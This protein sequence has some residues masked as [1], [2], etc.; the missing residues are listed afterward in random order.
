MA[1]EQTMKGEYDGSRNNEMGL[2]MQR[3]HQGTNIH[4][5]ALKWHCFDLNSNPSKNGNLQKFGQQKKT[6]TDFR[7]RNLT[8]T[9]RQIDQ[10]NAEKMK[11]RDILNPQYFSWALKTTKIW[12]V[13]WL[14]RKTPTMSC[15]HLEIFGKLSVNGRIKKLWTL[16]NNSECHRV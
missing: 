12:R 14:I 15:R 10:T 16:L 1:N 3:N 8:S 5:P 7:T 13:S 9:N 6:L 11:T 2:R 4:H